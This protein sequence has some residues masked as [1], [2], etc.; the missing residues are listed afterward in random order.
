[1][2]TNYMLSALD[3]A[4]LSAE[5]A[6]DKKA[7][8][9]QVLDLRGLTFITDYFVICSCGSKTQVSA[10]TDGI[11]ERLAKA[12]RLPMH[13]EGGAEATWVLMD[14]GD[15]VVHVF[16]EQTRLYYGLEK[17]WADAPRVALP[18]RTGA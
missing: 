3:T 11:T 14:Y 13:I 6:D 12:G 8:D 1:M 4:L 16:E 9:I 7:F 15:V 10:V 17:L 2:K 5:S 18:A